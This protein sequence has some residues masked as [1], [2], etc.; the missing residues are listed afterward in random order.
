MVGSSTAGGVP[1]D[2]PSVLLEVVCDLEGDSKSTINE[3]LDVGG[4]TAGDSPE[5]GKY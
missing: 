1:N 4:F 5:K 2:T 3:S